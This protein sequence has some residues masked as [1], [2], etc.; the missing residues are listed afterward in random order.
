MSARNKPNPASDD[1]KSLGKLALRLAAVALAVAMMVLGAVYLHYRSYVR[2]PVLEEGESVTLVIPKNTAWPQVVS[3]LERADLVRRST[4]FEYWARRRHLPPAVKAGTYELSGPLGLPELASKLR[5]GGKVDE[6][7]V[8][9]PE[10]LTI[11][12]MADRVERLG[13]ASRDEFLRAARDKQALQ[14]AGIDADSFEGY[15]FPD[16]YRFRKGTSAAKIVERMHGRWKV[17]WMALEKQHAE[18]KKALAEKYEFD[19]HDFVTLASLVERETSADGERDLIA[20]VFLN[21]LDRD[22]RLQTDP[23]CVYGEETYD[24]V[25]RPKYCKDKLN[26]YSTYVIDGLPPGPIANPGRGSL[27]AALDPSDEED[28]KGYL[29]FVARRDGT[30]RHYFSKTFAEHKKAIRRFLK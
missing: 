21:R 7:V 18:R 3:I 26:R 19:R 17:I 13:L 10:G 24:K 9:F 30:M 25:P 28:A 16:T 27:Q 12:H 15:L 29:F 14:K 6:T 20:R 8:T 1:S 5:E 4:Y 2:S 22:M 23:T 11:F